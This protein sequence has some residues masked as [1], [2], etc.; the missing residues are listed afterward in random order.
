MTMYHV[1]CPGNQNQ[2]ERYTYKWWGGVLIWT[3]SIDILDYLLTFA[4]ISTSP[5]YKKSYL[6]FAKRR[7]LALCQHYAQ[8]GYFMLKLC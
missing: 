3:S 7:F 4:Q 6:K 8:A 1:T 2:T 5:P